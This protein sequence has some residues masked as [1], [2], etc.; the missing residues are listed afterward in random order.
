MVMTTFGDSLLSVNSS[1]HSWLW[2]SSHLFHFKCPSDSISSPASHLFHFLWDCPVFGGDKG[3]WAHHGLQTFYHIFFHFSPPPSVL[4][5]VIC[6]GLYYCHPAQHPLWPHTSGW[7]AFI[8]T[9]IK[10]NKWR[11]NKAHQQIGADCICPRTVCNS[12]VKHTKT[13]IT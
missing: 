5:S 3:L 6:L 12:R 11:K 7:M 9:F 1:A 8:S 4:F 10:R 13:L 2:G